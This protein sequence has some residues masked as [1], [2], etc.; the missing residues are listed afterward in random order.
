MSKTLVWRQCDYCNGSVRCNKDNPRK[1]M[2][3]HQNKQVCIR[4]SF[5]K[6]SKISACRRVMKEKDSENE[7]GIKSIKIDQ[8]NSATEGIKKLP[9]S[10]FF[11]QTAFQDLER[12]RDALLALIK[13]PTIETV[14]NISPDR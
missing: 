2:G 3:I 4:K 5:S 6:T 8:H 13:E 7:F 10:E 12:R 9:F 14:R 11:E 1:S